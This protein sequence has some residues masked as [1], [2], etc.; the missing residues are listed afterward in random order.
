MS[1]HAW[2]ILP[3]TVLL[4]LGG[5]GGDNDRTDGTDSGDSPAV[6]LAMILDNGKG[7]THARVFTCDEGPD[8][9]L[10]DRLVPKLLSERDEACTD[11]WGGPQ[12]FTI[13]GSYRGQPVDLVVTRANGCE[14]SRFDRW[15]RLFNRTPS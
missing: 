9:K 5:C 7:D 13:T 14:I 3:L 6:K 11:L 8:C 15:Q 12:T 4:L 10:A 1:R 2:L